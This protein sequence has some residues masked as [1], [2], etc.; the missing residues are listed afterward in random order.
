VGSSLQLIFDPINNRPWAAIK[1][2][3]ELPKKRNDTQYRFGIGEWYG[4][5]FVHLSPEQRKFYASIQ[6]LPKSQRPAQLCPF[7][8]RANNPVNCTK[9]GGICSLRSYEKSEGVGLVSIDTRGSTLRTTCPNRF[10]ESGTIYQWIGKTILDDENAIALGETPFLESILDPLSTQQK[11]RKVGRID[12][13]LVSSHANSIRDWCPVEKQAVYFS[14]KQMALEFEAMSASQPS[15]N[16]P[17][18]LINRRLDYRSSGPKRLLPQLEIKVPILSTWGKKMA[19]VVDEDFF[20]Q[21]GRMKETNHLSNA[22]LVWFVVKY[23]EQRGSFQLQPKK[24]F[25][26]RLQ[27]AIE[28]LVAGMAIPRA[29]FEDALK[30]K[31]RGII[32][33]S[34]SSSPRAIR[35]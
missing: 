3:A 5:S 8:S 29:Q 26:T 20:D 12:N 11:R 21:L 31:L 4:K 34:A 2:E 19:L 17:F 24:I 30:I 32:Q 10:E 35:S 14:G 27:A 15:Q 6:Y 23:V 9:A 18:P 28:G 7:R 1:S 33:A 25:I 16:L 13:V 22:E